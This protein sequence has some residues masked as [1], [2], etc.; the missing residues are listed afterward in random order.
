MDVGVIHREIANVQGLIRFRHARIEVFDFC[1]FPQFSL[2][3]ELH[4]D[5]NLFSFLLVLCEILS[6]IETII[7]VFSHIRRNSQNELS[8]YYKCHWF[9]LENWSVLLFLMTSFIFDCFFFYKM[10]IR[11]WLFWTFLFFFNI[12]SSKYSK[13]I[14]NVTIIFNQYLSFF[15]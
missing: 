1:D 14:L 13:I 2:H 4:N 8:H 6:M 7:F 3:V 12:N 9:L 15:K 5:W 11:Y 10:H